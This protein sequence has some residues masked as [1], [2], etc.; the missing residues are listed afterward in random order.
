MIIKILADIGLGFMDLIFNQFQHVDLT[1]IYQ[2]YDKMFDI[3]SVVCYFLPMKTIAAIF[4]TIVVLITT[5]IVIM[6]LKTI[7]EI[8]PIL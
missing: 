4:S 5:K 7:W 3:L 8:I 6:C 1:G 2:A